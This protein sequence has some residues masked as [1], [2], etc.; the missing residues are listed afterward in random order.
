MTED[1]IAN[2]RVNLVMG[3]ALLD[4]DLKFPQ[5]P[6]ITASGFGKV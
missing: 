6:A 4:R 5:P 2:R 1:D 3:V